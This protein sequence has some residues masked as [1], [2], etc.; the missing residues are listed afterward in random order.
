[1][2][3]LQRFDANAETRRRLRDLVGIFR[4][5]FCEPPQTRNE[6]TAAKAKRR[7]HHAKALRRAGKS[8]ADA[9][10]GL[11]EPL[12][13]P[14]DAVEIQPPRQAIEARLNTLDAFGN[15]VMAARPTSSASA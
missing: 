2:H 6:P 14:R 15:A 11:P 12:C 8:D 3:F 10:E 5:A 13:R 7:R 4:R 9:V 1:L